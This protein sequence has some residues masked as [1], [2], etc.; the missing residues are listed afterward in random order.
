MQSNTKLF[1]KFLIL[2]LIINIPIRVWFIFEYHV[3]ASE[4]VELFF[5]MLQYS[6]LLIIPLLLHLV[7]PTRKLSRTTTGFRT[8]FRHFLFLLPALIFNFVALMA[9]HLFLS[10]NLL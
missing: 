5:W 10:R 6:Q 3:T 4:D 9:I 7:Y 1:F 8:F 2:L